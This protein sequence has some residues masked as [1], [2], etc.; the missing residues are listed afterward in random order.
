MESYDRSTLSI[1]Q[2]VV[3]VANTLSE[4]LWQGGAQLRYMCDVSG[5]QES[6][7]VFMW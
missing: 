3:S 6:Q 7:P 2:L 5:P 4:L 1:F